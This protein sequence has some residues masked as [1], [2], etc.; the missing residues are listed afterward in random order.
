MFFFELV[1]LIHFSLSFLFALLS[2]ISSFALS[3]HLIEH[4]RVCT[5]RRCVGSSVLKWSGESITPSFRAAVH[6]KG[7]Q[8]N[9]K[10]SWLY[11]VIVRVHLASVSDMRRPLFPVLKKVH[12][13]PCYALVATSATRLTICD[14]KRLCAREN[15]CWA[16][17]FPPSA[18]LN[19]SVGSYYFY[20][21]SQLFLSI[22]SYWILKMISCWI[23]FFAFS[24]FCF[25]I[26]ILKFSCALSN[27]ISHWLDYTK[28]RYG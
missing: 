25:I 2:F 12:F 14:E 28:I 26:Y 6:S 3:L 16:S 17:A 11:D 9:R 23:H 27:L 18:L 4:M 22:C 19:L 5:W 8:S 1:V 20:I 15:A 13:G 21:Y 24:R 10:L 7:C